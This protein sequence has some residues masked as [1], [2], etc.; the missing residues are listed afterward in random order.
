MKGERHRKKWANR[1]TVECIVYT[2]C[3]YATTSDKNSR[4]IEWYMAA[5]WIC[6]AC[7][8]ACRTHFCVID[9]AVAWPSCSIEKAKS[10]SPHTR[11]RTHPLE[12]NYLLR[13]NTKLLKSSKMLAIH[14]EQGPTLWSL[15]PTKCRPIFGLQI[16]HQLQVLS[17]SVFVVVGFCSICPSPCYALFFSDVGIMFVY[18]EICVFFAFPNWKIKNDI[19]GY[20]DGHNNSADVLLY[21]DERTN[22]HECC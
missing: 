1:N 10:Y 20:G 12:R 19:S 5:L 2:A 11:T 18:L 15:R 8:I 17:D 14:N 4:R 13:T 22:T 7:A 16:E 9:G 21:T 6:C 3:M